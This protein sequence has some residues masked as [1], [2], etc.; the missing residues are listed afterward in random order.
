MKLRELR[1]KFTH[2]GG[3]L[4]MMSMDNLR[5][6]VRQMDDMFGLMRALTL[7]NERDNL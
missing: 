4:M 1:D 5:A 7:S 2:L 3:T 6:I